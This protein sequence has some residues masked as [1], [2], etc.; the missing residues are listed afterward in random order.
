MESRCSECNGHIVW[1][2]DGIICCSMCG[3]V[4]DN[5]I[6]EKIS[7][8]KKPRS[9]NR[10]TFKQAYRLFQFKTAKQKR[11]ERRGRGL[12][13]LDKILN[14][15]RTTVELSTNLKIRLLHPSKRLLLNLTKQEIESLCKV[16]G[17]LCNRVVTN[18]QH[19]LTN[20]FMNQL[21]DLQKKRWIHSRTM[22]D[23]AFVLLYRLLVKELD[24]YTN[25]ATGLSNSYGKREPSRIFRL[26]AIT[27]LEISFVGALIDSLE[28][29]YPERTELYYRRD[30]PYFVKRKTQEIE[31]ELQ[32]KYPE[33]EIEL[34]PF[35]PWRI[36]PALF[37]VR[38][39]DLWKLFKMPY[40]QG[41]K[42]V[43]MLKCI[44]TEVRFKAEQR[45]KSFLTNSTEVKLPCKKLGL[46]A[47]CCYIETHLHE[48]NNYQMF[49]PLYDYCL[50]QG[51]K[52]ELLVRPVSQEEWAKAF[53]ITRQTLYNRI[54]ELNNHDPS[55]KKKIQLVASLLS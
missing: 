10:G 46:N 7:A 31:K 1:N 52:S 33:K 36:D 4:V 44:E 47:A 39:G 55:I 32:K 41:E 14:E 30:F 13:D 18:F 21:G 48:F 50:K 51:Y 17:D 38:K 3:L 49:L 28:A 2:S 15:L 53:G 23:T 19:K 43:D 25:M 29:R 24:K 8:N 5:K 34:I 22:E 40:Y 45:F 42:P 35:Y 6:L 20:E 27:F 26:L 9:Y 11:L 12:K 16:D 54:R 37:N